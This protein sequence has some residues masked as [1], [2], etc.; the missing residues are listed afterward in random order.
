VRKILL[1][2]LVAAVTSCSLKSE[3]ARVALPGTNLVLV[4]EEDEKR[5]TRYHFL[6]G[7]TASA[8][9]FLGPPNAPL[10]GKVKV[11]DN[12]GTIRLSWGPE[13]LGQFVVIDTIDCRIVE[14]S[15][16]AD[17]PPRIIGCARHAPAA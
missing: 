1:L 15:N 4:L 5:M 12:Q 13:G 16:A 9:G 8:E 2:I 6:V 3:K 11:S 10:D 7:D 17:P 14:H